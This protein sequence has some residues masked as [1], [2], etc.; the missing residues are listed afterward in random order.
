MTLPGETSRLLDGLSREERARLFQELRR[1]KAAAV[2]TVP[3]QPTSPA[4][5]GGRGDLPLSFAQQRLWFLDRIAPGS[6]VY[7]VPSALRLLGALRP[8]VLA[9]CFGEVLRRHE[10]LRTRFE[11]RGDQ[12][13]Q[14]IE[15]A[16]PLEI[17]LIDLTGLPAALRPAE[18]GRL[19]AEEALLPFDL[20]RPPL[21]RARLVRVD[22]ADHLLLLTL[23]HIASDAWSAGIALGEVTALY[24]A[25]DAGRPSPLP[26]PPIQYADYAREQRAALRADQLA[27][28]VS[29]WRERLAGAPALDLPAD[30]PRPP[31][32]SFRGVMADV[33]V[34]A[35]VSAGLHRLAREERVTLF[36]VLLA[37]FL[38]L[39]SRLTGA[40]DVV[41]GTTVTG[42]N[43]RELETLIGFF[44]N[45]LVLRTDV[46]G[47]PGARDLLLR[48]RETVLDA[49]GHQEVPFEKLVDELGLP[50]DPY[51]PP[52]L[53]VVLQ[54][55]VHAEPPR[56]ERSALTLSPYPPARESAKFDLVLNVAND[57]EG[58]VAQWLYDTDLFDA[59]TI[60]RFS[61]A[62]VALLTAWLEAPEQ[63]LSELPLLTAAERHQL[64]AEWDPGPA[65]AGRGRGC[66][67]RRFEEQADRTPEAPAV[68]C[69][70]ERLTYR[71]L[72]VRADRLARHLAAAGVRPGDVVG[73]CL[74]QS[75]DLV[76]ALLA[77]LKAGAAYLPLDPASPTERLAFALADSGAALVITP[78]FLKAEREAVAAGS[79]D[80][81]E[82]ESDPE[83]PAYVIY[84]SGSTGRPKGVVI[85]H[86][87]VTRLFSATAPWFGFA[88]DDVWTLFHSFAFDFSVWEI[89]GA[90]LHGGR[91]VIVPY[92]ES[93]SPEAFY[94]L[95]GDEGVTVLNQT[96]SA[97]RQLLWAEDAALAGSL[98]L[99]LVIFGG[100][101]LEPASLAPWIERH[102]DE[103][104]RLVNMYGITETTV[105]VTYRPIRREDV[106]RGSRS[107]IGRA[108]PDLAVRVLGRSLQPQP[109]G[110]VGEICVG[111]E[112]LALGYL[113]R[114]ELT[115]ERFVPDP[116][117][118]PGAR[119]YRSGDLARRLPDGELEYVGRSDHQVKIRGFRIEP[120]EVEAAILSHPDI[121]EAVVLARGD[122][123]GGEP[124]LVAYVTAAREGSET[125]PSL[126]E[127]RS[128]LTASLPEYMLPAALVTLDRL[129]LTVNGKVDRRALPAPET[130]GA[131]APSRQTVAP[132]DE[133]ERFLAKLFRDVLR[134]PEEGEIGIADDF[135]VLG[136]SSITGAIL[137]NR[138]QEALGEI[139]QV[140]VIFD[141]PNVSA[142][143]AYVREQH[144]AAA[145]RLWGG[146]VAEAS[147][148]SQDDGPP[149]PDD[150]AV[151]RRLIETSRVEPSPGIEPEPV[152]PPALFV[153][154]PP[155]SGSTLLRVMLGI[156]PRL[157]AP[158]ELEL[159]SFQTLAERR[160]AFQGRDSFWLEGA[161]RAAMEARQCS[162]SEA[163]AL[164]EERERRGWTTRR[165]YRELQGWLAADGRML[166]DKTP[167]YALD[168]AVLRRA[169]EGFAGARYLHL[170]RHPQAANR[171]FE[172]AKLDQI[173]FRRPHPFSRRQL[174]ELV[175]TVSQRNILDFLAGVPEERRWTVRF[176]DLVRDPER[177][178]AGI[179]GFLGIDF[180][181]GMAE[182]Y[183]TGVAR[184][185]DGVHAVSR[186]LGDVKFHRHGKV[187]PSSAERWRGTGQVPLGGPA[188]ELAA[189]LGYTV[190]D[191]GSGIRRGLRGGRATAPLSFSQERLWFL[192]R[193]QPGSAA[194]NIPGPLR[195][196]GPLDPA[197]LAR[198][199]GEVRRRHEAL[200]TRF[201]TRGGVPVQVIDPIDLPGEQ[202]ALPCIDLAA[203]PE[204]L[205]SREAERLTGEEAGWPFD[206][207]RGPLW[208]VIL[209][210]LSAEEHGLLLTVHHIVSDGWSMRVL[211][212]E[213]TVFYTAFSADC[214][215]PLPELPVQYADFALWQRERL[216]GPELGRQVAYWRDRLGG[217]P[218]VLDLPLDR[219]RPALQTFRGAAARAVLPRGLAD[220]LRRLGFGARASLFMVLIAG[221][222]ALLHRFSGQDNILVGTPVAGRVRPEVEGLI[223]FFLNTLVLR[224]DLAGRPGFA[225]LVRRVRE[226]A[227]GAYAHQD[228]PFEKLLAELQPERDLSRTP[229]FQVFFNLANFA[230]E[231]IRLPG[232]VTVEPLAGA[233]VESKFDLTIYASEG[234]EGIALNLVY[235]ADLFDA[236]RMEE[237]LRQYGL[238]LERGVEEPEMP[239][240][241]FPLVT[242]AAAALLPDPAAPLAEEWRGPV[243]ALFAE[244][245]R[246]HP[247]RPAVRGG[248]GVWTYGDLAAA[249]D[250]LASRLR[251]AGVRRGDRV[252][253]WAHR[254]APVA[255]AVLGTL[256]AGAV[257]V[258][259]DPAYPPSR[260]VEILR[261]AEPRAWLEV[262]AAGPP[263]REVEEHLLASAA[264]GALLCRLALPGV[265]EEWTDTDEKDEQDG[266]DLGPDDLA[267][268][269]FTSGSTG[270]PK[271]ILGR[272]GPLSHFLPWQCERFGLTGEDRYSLLS[273]LAHDPLQRDIFTPLC[274][275]ATLCVPPA[276]EVLAPG[277]L[278][279]WAA[280][281]GITVA[282]LTPAMAQLLTET[283][284][285]QI[286]PALRYVLLVGD[287]LTRLDVERIRRLAPRAVCV[288][289]YGSTETQRAVGYH[290]AAP[291]SAAGERARQILPLGRGMRGV[292][293]LV[294]TPSGQLAGIGELG[295]IQVRS[296][297]LA[298]GY[299]GDEALTAERFR[300]NPFTGIGGDRVYRTGDLGRYLPDGEVAFAGR[301]DQ[302]VKVRGFRIELGE[303]EAALG[304]LPGVREAVV[305]ARASAGGTGDR[306]LVAYVTPAGSDTAL[307][308]GTLRDGLR[309]LLPAYMVPAAF[310]P[311]PRLPVTPNGKVD[312]KALARIEP[313]GHDAGLTTS[314]VEP[315]SDLER[316]I[317]ALW[318]EVLGVEQ[319][320]VRHNFFDLGGHSLLLVRLHARLE[321]ELGR[322][323]PLVDL[324]NAPTIE[325]LARHLDRQAAEEPAREGAARGR[326]E[327]QIEAARRQKEQ[328]RARR[329]AR[330]AAVEE[331]E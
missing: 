181:P 324:F 126:G 253:V 44:I 27:R 131:P 62:L 194:Y 190:D 56:A 196:R 309:S 272:H 321:E 2:A 57:P 114:P 77:V 76:V 237:M 142:L 138:L 223:G 316:R 54:L 1:K 203:L 24:P 169:E 211:L 129:P 152:N 73:L 171:S 100:E 298:R 83:A 102:G 323:L 64:L 128:F 308:T 267:Y 157:F 14:V 40:E 305:L 233:E 60:G 20:T 325:A 151:M 69:G 9:A 49:F 115:A 244:R 12:P 125:V 173:F 295:E 38:A 248:D 96:P 205:R 285:E 147:E 200:R 32:P 271:G 232:G 189:E 207:D 59:T 139:V 145:A 68:S 130:A 300:T 98:R 108:I 265:L 42:R 106:V 179:C 311:L 269:A 217:D 220:G 168:L 328:A 262:S 22:A 188:R 218:P 61:S 137:I 289:L 133:L 259:L 178:L 112:G 166:V 3:P 134:L 302:Q 104:P 6:P 45:T 266:Q 11:I 172:E 283:G 239:V 219:P 86:G 214:P 281:E 249:V 303:I 185:T 183:R 43:R 290:V 7:N 5:G 110:V 132:R 93:R 331:G 282:H 229:L 31:V 236:P 75:L 294:V 254:S 90:L 37:P 225:E 264:G 318:R 101:A 74:E 216:A 80:R 124:R 117:G 228:V 13:V 16:R 209:L 317:A 227:V 150:V 240:D 312:R 235:N 310:V 297:H 34:P 251:A 121:R 88:A 258:M 193:L 274:T 136:G 109:M 191:A 241:A 231:E 257:F 221:F 327:R 148:A 99:R 304:R 314:Y 286:L 21:L 116:W 127:L 245:A 35:G 107:P 41:V 141:A 18:E 87:N 288:N 315:R 154:S 263:P 78:D 210:R 243:H 79:G 92:W 53:R 252:A 230:E 51:R 17:P 198:C 246:R 15:P 95:L 204:P 307:D 94:R 208:R 167:S 143:A 91:L 293:L 8:A 250:R 199:C 329:A 201:E 195:L 202:A 118:D 113:G 119:L 103:H 301:T 313:E 70:G 50:R 156:H 160:A 187:D 175:W 215:S 47:D 326:A 55:Y 29:F 287:V 197:V 84:T 67:H 273:G 159:L 176:E 165:F 82:L 292:Q 48:A 170:V 180:H 242:A 213:L 319:V 255:W 268:V 174:A 36:T 320:G 26:E 226:V 120:G 111:G 146:G 306:R 238:L 322:E 71:E 58:L 177:V 260:L 28:E 33:A 186:M 163:E 97:F 277:R 206:L 81:R 162:A 256:R 23:H 52:L 122:G 153:L 270:V 280:R 89:W 65:G 296:P 224:T 278:A 222:A 164:I 161:V 275:G 85:P 247:E 39:L 19:A 212:R 284:G 72:D 299:L 105:H 135:F 276:E 66:L 155:R 234:D 291:G 158:P 25:F 149:G 184:M 30:R 144:P 279:A 46:S 10:A 330:P 123:P 192:D 140:V 4:A 261:L 182:P 63:R